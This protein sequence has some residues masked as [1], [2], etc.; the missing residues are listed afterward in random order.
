MEAEEEVG[1]EEEE[2]GERRETPKAGKPVR[3]LRS[4]QLS[5]LAIA[6]TF[7]KRDSFVIVESLKSR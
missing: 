2:E 4:W 5:A 6:V 3:G 1:E 7:L